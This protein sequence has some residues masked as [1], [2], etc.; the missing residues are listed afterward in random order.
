[1]FEGAKAKVHRAETHISDF[2]RIWNGFVESKPYRF[3]VHRN[4]KDGQQTIHVKFERPLPDDIP[5]I[6]ADAIHNL[7]VALDQ[8]AWELAG[9]GKG[10]QDRSTKFIT[11]SSK[12]EYEKACNAIKT[13]SDWVKAI[14]LS[15]EAFPG[16]RG[17]EI[18]VLSDLNNG[19]KHRSTAPVMKASSHPPFRIVFANGGEAIFENNYFHGID[20]ANVP[21]VHAPPDSQ[22]IWDSSEAPAPEIFCP[23]PD[24]TSEPAWS[25][26]RGLRNAVA[27]SIA[28]IER[29]IPKRIP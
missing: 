1:M 5:F 18:W 12:A 24:G 6:I 27:G 11:A 28:D 21:L 26:L 19:D 23:K 7:R 15:Q 20:G 22:I 17:H 13:P 25:M 14:M 16:G 2:N 9:I 8:T 29:K 4:G 10:V 3:E